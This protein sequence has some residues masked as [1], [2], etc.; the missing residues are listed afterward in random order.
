MSSFFLCKRRS[1]LTTTKLAILDNKCIGY[2]V[3]ATVGPFSWVGPEDNPRSFPHSQRITA[4][5]LGG[6]NHALE[7]VS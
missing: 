4:K 1:G 2:P 5:I 3:C 6:P 7:L